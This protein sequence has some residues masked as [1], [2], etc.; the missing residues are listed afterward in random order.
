MSLPCLLNSCPLIGGWTT[1]F[2]FSL[3]FMI[4]SGRSVTQHFKRD[5]MYRCEKCGVCPPAR[6]PCKK[7]VT[8]KIRFLH[9]ERPYAIKVIVEKNGKKKTAWIPDPGGWGDQIVKETKM[10]P[11]CATRWEKAQK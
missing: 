5:A 10:C 7:V 1:S 8:R 4:K 9:P 3:G 2:D 11:T 6:T